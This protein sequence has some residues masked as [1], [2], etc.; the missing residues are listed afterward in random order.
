MHAASS[1]TKNDRVGLKE[2]STKVIPWIHRRFYIKG[3]DE[4]QIV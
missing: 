2:G 1:I 4:G 3:T